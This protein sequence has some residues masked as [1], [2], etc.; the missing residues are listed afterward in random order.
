MTYYWQVEACN[1]ASCTI[2]PVWS[3]TTAGPPPHLKWD[4]PPTVDPEYHDVYFYGFDEESAY[5]G[6]QI[7]ADDWGCY[8]G[9]SV[10]GIQWWGSYI[11]WDNEEP[12][13]TTPDHFHVAIWT[14]NPAE[15]PS[16]WNVPD[17]VIWEW[18]VPRSELNESWA[19]MEG[20]TGGDEESCFKYEFDIPEEQWFQQDLEGNNVYWI[21]ISARYA[22]L[23]RSATACLASP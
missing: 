18:V 21:S 23:V 20:G 1:P 17:E 6:Y 2:G 9:R 13:F 11:D 15:L 5:D 16:G 10:T 12:P 14:D 8:D 7:V 3:F 4:Q 19:N 22:L